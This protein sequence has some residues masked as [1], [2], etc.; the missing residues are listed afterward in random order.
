SINYD[1]FHDC[2]SLTNI[3]VPDSV[4][5]IGDRAFYNCS[6]LASIEIPDSVTSIGG[7]AFSNCSSLASIIIP[8]SVTSIGGYAFSYCSSLTNITIP[9]SVTSIDNGT[10]YGCSNLTSVTI[11]DGVTS[12]GMRAFYNCNNLKS[13]T[14]PNSVTSI[15]NWAFCGCSGL[16]S[17]TFKTKQDIIIDITTFISCENLKNIYCYKNSTADNFFTAYKY[18]QIYKIYLDDNEEDDDFS[19]KVDLSDFEYSFFAAD[20]YVHIDKYVGNGEYVVIPSIIEGREV[21]TI[22][23]EAFYNCQTVKSIKIPLSISSI[24]YAAFYKCDS[25]TDVYYSG[26]LDDW[27]KIDIYG[28]NGKLLNA[29]HHFTQDNDHYEIKLYSNV[30]MFLLAKGQKAGVAVQLEKNGK[31]VSGDL[32][33]AYVVSNS[34]IVTISDIGRGYDGD[35]FYLNCLKEG[36]TTFTITEI[37]TGTILST[38]VIV[39]DN[40]HSFNIKSLEQAQDQVYGYNAHISGMFIENLTYYHDILSQTMT[41]SF[42]VYN[43][44]LTSGVASV[45]DENNKLINVYPIGRFDGN[46]ITSLTDTVLTSVKLLEDVFSGDIS[47]YRASTVSKLTK[48]TIPEVP[49]GGHIEIS[50]DI[51][52]SDACLIYNTTELLVNE[53][54]LIY[55]LVNFSDLEIEFD[56]SYVFD[57]SKYIAKDLLDDLIIKLAQSMPKE[58]K[59]IV[60][61]MTIYY[62]DSPGQANI[63]DAVIN[64]AEY[65]VSVFEEHGIDVLEMIESFSMNAG[66]PIAEGM[67]KKALQGAGKGLSIMFTFSDVCSFLNFFSY[68]LIDQPDNALKIQFNNQDGN[69]TNG[70][71]S[72]SPT[73]G[74]TDFGFENFVMRS[75]VLSSDSDLSGEMKDNL[76]N[77]SQNYVVRD[78]YLE[79]DGQITQPGQTVQV[80][81]PIPESFNPKK[82]SIY[83]IKDDGTIE[84]IPA[85]LVGENLVFCTNHFSYYA[86][87]E[88]KFEPG[89]VNGDQLIN[90]KDA[91]L[92]AQYLAGWEVEVVDFAA[93]C[94]DDGEISIKDAVLLAQH[95]AGWNVTLG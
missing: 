29:N 44:G 18:P 45:Y 74:S 83:W 92:L 53:L 38:T 16:T 58:Y 21:T 75:I 87:V 79:K 65:M 33:F 64:H 59:K 31:S 52:Y 40:I 15:G 63:L 20:K 66:L 95:L 78:V 5:S 94:K 76:D 60:D 12:I 61:K 85:T 27:R 19:D 10:F 9:E 46:Y 11:S 54:M 22:S 49:Y 35:T 1:T 51:Y 80:S 91:V 8:N 69:L 56:E 70:G 14:I 34:D 84:Y 13:V 6:S 81:I 43:T 39:T 50:N 55:K 47:N 48:I 26:T 4:T 23:T 73:D 82:C 57:I 88:E 89:D 41:V 90:I 62:L 72:I 30:S 86:I 36:E 93:D 71:V 67:F 25:L 2:S 42:D 37:E 28:L 32:N 24:G 7:Y 77:I 3:T 17:V 68:L